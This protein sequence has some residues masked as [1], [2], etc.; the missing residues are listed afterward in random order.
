MHSSSHGFV[1]TRPALMRQKLKM[2]RAVITAA[3][4]PVAGGRKIAK[5]YSIERAKKMSRAWIFI[6]PETPRQD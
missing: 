1:T 2:S 4:V 3:T 5:I 6:D